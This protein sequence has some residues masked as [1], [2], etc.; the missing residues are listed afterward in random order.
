MCYVACN[1]SNAKNYSSGCQVSSCN[2]GWT[3]GLDQTLN[4]TKCVSKNKCLCPN[5]IA[6]SGEK[7]P[8]DGAKKCASCNPGFSLAANQNACIGTILN[9][10][11][12]CVVYSTCN[13]EFD[14]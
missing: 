3:V 13:S 5:G 8:S 10:L 1:V 14:P 11:D 4:R 12:N 9:L 2:T 7:C 6:A